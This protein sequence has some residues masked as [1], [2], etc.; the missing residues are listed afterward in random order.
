MLRALF[1]L[2][3]DELMGHLL[4][5]GQTVQKVCYRPGTGWGVCL[6]SSMGPYEVTEL[7]FGV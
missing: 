6:R 2:L 1:S 5:P 4:F 7:K 3:Q